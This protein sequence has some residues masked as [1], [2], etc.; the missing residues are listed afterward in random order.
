M[1]ALF[2]VLSEDLAGNAIKPPAPVS[3]L[4]RIVTTSLG[5]QQTDDA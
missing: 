3:Y 2:S 5:M 4:G 1:L